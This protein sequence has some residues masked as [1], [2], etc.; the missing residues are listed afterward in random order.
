MGLRILPG[1]Q[2]CRRTTLRLG[3]PAVAEIALDQAEDALGLQEALNRTGAAPLALGFGS[4][5]LA[6]DGQ[7]P[8]SVVS[9]AAPGEP[10][11]RVGF[12]LE[13]K[14][15]VAAW[16]GLGLPKLLGWLARRGFSGLEGLSGVPGS[17]AGAVAGNA[18]SYGCDLAGVLRRVK[19]Y[20]PGSG[21]KWLEKGQWSAGYRR[22]AP[23]G[24]E[25]FYLVL[26]VELELARKSPD[27]VRQAMRE[28]LTKKRATQPLR[29]ASAGCVFKNPAAQSAG[30]ILDS[31]GFKG[32]RMGNMAF[33]DLHANFLVNLGGGTT[34]A[35]MELI[36]QARDKA[37]A[38]LGIELELEVK[39]I[40]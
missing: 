29:A 28:A 2:L 1:P 18:G 12:G 39:V 11:E 23:L 36:G 10:E 27:A 31:L 9:L 15:V 19:I 30:K 32:K 3:G 33:S 37:K 21:L 24:V 35:A 6:M 4:N 26:E 20:A 8:L 16:A 14:A 22:F 5:I 38:E 7:L 25:G 13:G 17:L 40:A 34:E